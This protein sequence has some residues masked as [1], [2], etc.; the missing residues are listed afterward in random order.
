MQSR[1]S[2]SNSFQ[3]RWA[4][5]TTKI[6]LH[7]KQCI[8]PMM[9]ISP[10]YTVSRKEAQESYS[11]RKETDS[12]CL[13]CQSLEYTNIQSGSNQFICVHINLKKRTNVVG[14]SEQKRKTA[15]GEGLLQAYVID[16]TLL[17]NMLEFTQLKNK[18]R[19]MNFYFA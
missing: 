2:N 4:E 1:N 8:K 3:N 12:R 17:K 13:C 15:V 5:F 7:K 19:F 9:I 6:N 16:F 18:D 10:A 11:G 14:E